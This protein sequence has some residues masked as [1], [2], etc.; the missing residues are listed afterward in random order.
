MLFIVSKQGPPAAYTLVYTSNNYGV[1]W[2]NHSFTSN[3]I[4]TGFAGDSVS[5]S[6]S[7]QYQIIS[8]RENPSDIPSIFVSNDYGASFNLNLSATP[9]TT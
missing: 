4:L 5:M 6:D 1:T 9:I 3:Y 8:V 7:G 2:Y